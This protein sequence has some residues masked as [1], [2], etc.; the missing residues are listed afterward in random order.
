MQRRRK[1]LVALVLSNCKDVP[2]NRIQLVKELQK[3]VTVDVY[4]KCGEFQCKDPIPFGCKKELGHEY[5]FYLSFENSVCQDYVTEKLFQA[6]GAEMVPIVFGG[7]NYDRIVPTGSFINANSFPS[8]KSLADYLLFLNS[9]DDEYLKYFEWKKSYELKPDRI[10]YDGGYCRL[11]QKLAVDFPKGTKSFVILKCKCS[12]KDV[13]AIIDSETKMEQL[14]SIQFSIAVWLSFTESCNAG[15]AVEI[16][17]EFPSTYPQACV[18]LN[19]SYGQE[20]LII[21]I[22]SNQNLLVGITPEES[23]TLTGWCTY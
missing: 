4:G 19:K 13:T 15:G 7:G 12:I 16:Y 8:A 23:I 9:D 1:K 14:S 10:D 17:P 22:K 21:S 11:C 18:N 5:K 3:Y 2:S 20:L 6:Y